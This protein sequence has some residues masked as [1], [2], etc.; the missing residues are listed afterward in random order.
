MAE[1]HLGWRVLETNADTR[2]SAMM[3]CCLRNM[4][5]ILHILRI[6]VPILMVR[7]SVRARIFIHRRFIERA[8]RV[9][10]RLHSRLVIGDKVDNPLFTPQEK[11]KSIAHK[12][13]SQQSYNN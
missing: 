2:V 1:R 3:R 9:V 10:H 5:H 12:C 11:K 8:L 4:R 6:V 7:A 13:S